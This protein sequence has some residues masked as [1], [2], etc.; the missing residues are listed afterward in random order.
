MLQMNVVLM[1]SSSSKYALVL[2]VGES[3][4]VRWTLAILWETRPVCWPF[5]PVFVRGLGENVHCQWQ[6]SLA[7]RLRASLVGCSAADSEFRSCVFCIL[8]L[9][10]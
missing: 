3:Q 5:Y 1:V 9:N 10:H 2:I 6:S 8:Q 4:P 7:G